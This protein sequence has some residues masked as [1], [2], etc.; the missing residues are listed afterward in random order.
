MAVSNNFTHL[1]FSVHLAH[2]HTHAGKWSERR[3]IAIT[4]ERERVWCRPA[5]CMQINY[6]R[7]GFPFLAKDDEADVKLWQCEN[8]GW[9]RDLLIVLILGSLILLRLI[10]FIAF[11]K[12]MW[13][14]TFAEISI[15]KNENG[16]GRRIWYNCSKAISWKLA[17]HEFSFV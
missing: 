3:A 5:W 4:R 9:L 11:R 17:L 6:T 14:K 16:R 15:P 13:K 2:T 7:D 10:T 12:F 8:S 1:N